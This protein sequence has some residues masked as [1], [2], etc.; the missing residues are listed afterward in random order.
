M[1]QNPNVSIPESTAT[2]KYLFIIF[3][4]LQEKKRSFENLRWVLAQTKKSHVDQVHF[5]MHL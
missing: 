4:V 3:M 2:K 5:S 1:L